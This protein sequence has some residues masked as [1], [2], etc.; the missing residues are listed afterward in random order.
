MRPYLLFIIIR[1]EQTLTIRFK[2]KITCQNQHSQYYYT[3][4]RVRLITVRA[5]VENANAYFVAG[6]LIALGLAAWQYSL[7]PQGTLYTHPLQ[8]S[9]PTSLPHRHLAFLWEFLV[10][11]PCLPLPAW[12]VSFVGL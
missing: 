8:A 1:T 12:L 9:N 3:D 6:L 10:C 2:K 4:A 5:T 7:A 11:V